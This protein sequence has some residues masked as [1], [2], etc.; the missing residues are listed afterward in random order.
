AVVPSMYEGFGLPVG[1]AMA[2]RVPVIS[3]TGGALPEV[4]GDAAKLVPPGDA[5]DLEKAIIELLDD[6]KQR[7]NLACLGYERVKREFTW[8]KC[9][10]R[11][12]QV[13]RE[14]IDDYHGL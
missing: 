4:A 13:Y 7:E 10:M 2:C 6:E 12:A 5:K 8:E 14:V 1:E 9:A 3:T 11:T